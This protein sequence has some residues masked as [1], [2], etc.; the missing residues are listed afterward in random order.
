MRFYGFNQVK[1]KVGIAGHDDIKRLRVIRRGVGKGVELRVDANEAWSPDEAVGRIQALEPFGLASV[2]QPVPHADL[3][4][5]ADVRRQVGTPIMLDESLCSPADAE[6][7]VTLRACDVFNLRLSKCGGFLPSLRLARFAREHGVA[8]QLGCQVGET[9]LLSAA[10]RHFAAS[11]ANLR[12]VEGSYDRH[13]VGEPLGT[14]DLTFGPGGRAPALARCGLGV[15]VDPEALARVTR[16]KET[17][18][19]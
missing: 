13:L 18:L 10:G 8:C 9:A 17:L 15:T 14:E 16:R 2:E 11:V 6:A 1:V 4:L 7:A 19:G 5:L 3:H 12:A